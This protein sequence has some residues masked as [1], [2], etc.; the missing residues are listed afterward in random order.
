MTT[1]SKVL[2]DADKLAEG[3]RRVAPFTG[4]GHDWVILEAH[5]GKVELTTSDGYRIAHLEL[6]LDFV[7]GDW[8]LE[9]GPAKDFA[10]THHQGAKLPVEAVELAQKVGASLIAVKVLKVGDVVLPLADGKAPDYRKLKPATFETMAIV[11]T[12][13]WIKPLRAHGARETSVGLVVGQAECRM[14]FYGYE[15]TLAVEQVAAQM[16]SGPEKRVCLNCEQLRRALTS[17][18]KEATIKFTANP[19]EPLLFESE[20][21]WHLL[22]PKV[23]EFPREM[24]FTQ[25]EK[26]ALDLAIETIQEV[27]RGKVV[28]R[29]EIGGGRF[30]LE[31]D[32]QRE[33]TEI[34]VR[35]EG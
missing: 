28:A 34:V 19:Q 27:R 21:Y 6:A 2:V 15:E 33:K 8:L 25:A 35:K 30:V 31:L 4:Q 22:M 11:E 18:G 24:V 3:L 13:K 20:G 17:C 9:A 16:V 14:L 10:T 12:R 23:G 5:G 29:V 7:E 1:A 26:E 32:P